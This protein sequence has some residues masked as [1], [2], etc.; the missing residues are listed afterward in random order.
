MGAFISLLQPAPR[1]NPTQAYNEGAQAAAQRTMEQAQTTNYL[2]NAQNQ[3][4]DIQQK[5]MQLDIQRRLAKAYQDAADRMKAKQGASPDG[6]SLP[7]TA[8]ATPPTASPTAP[9]AGASTVLAP[10]AQPPATSAP[11]TDGIPEYLRPN[12]EAPPVAAVSPAVPAGAAAA[13]MPPVSPTPAPQQAVRPIP[14]PAQA[15]PTQS[16]QSPGDDFHAELTRS[17]NENGLGQMVPGVNKQYSDMVIAQAKS[18][19]DT[20]DAHA[21]VAAQATQLIQGIA[22][23]PPEQRDAQYQRVLP[24]LA[25]LEQKMGGDPSQVPSTWDDSRMAVLAAQGTSVTEYANHLHQAAE[26][27]RLT[28]EGIINNAP[29]AADYLQREVGATTSPQQYAEL[30]QRIGTYAAAEKQANPNAPSF[31]QSALSSY[32][33]QW[34]PDVAKDAT[35][36]SLKPDERVTYFTKQLNDSAQRLKSAALSGPTAYTAELAA[37]TAKNPE[38]ANLF[39]PAPA[40]GAKWDGTGVATQAA[41]VGATGEQYI[42]AQNTMQYREDLLNIRDRLADISQQRADTAQQKAD[43]AR[44]PK[45]LTPAQVMVEKRRLDADENGTP[46]RPGG[47]TGLRRVLG[48]QLQAGAVVDKDGKS[49]P[50]TRDSRAQLQAKYN[51][52]TDFHQSLQFQKADLYG[53]QRPDLVS[54]N[55]AKDGETVAGPDGSAWK[56]QDG[57]MY[58]QAPGSSASVATPPPAT[59]PELKQDTQPT[60]KAGDTKYINGKAVKITKVYPDGTADYTALK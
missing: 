46:S 8:A 36:S 31:W 53:I 6:S 7:P 24:Q 49:I 33:E 40:P 43:Q 59:P 28:Q 1:E 22:Q 29:K 27:A 55:E 13:L 11:S 19:S 45:G 2:E 21:K 9:Q 15:A 10:Q 17:L 20:A 52:A 50:L 58:Y 25:S 12:P 14:A 5:Q 57:V 44:N 26:T 56:K 34:S 54:I 38:V 32:P 39:A 3:Q 4:L 48:S 35:L 30:R 37:Q 18:V 47:V 42:T 51:A 16:W 60:I 23:L 41:N